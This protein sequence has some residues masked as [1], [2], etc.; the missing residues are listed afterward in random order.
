MVEPAPSRVESAP[1]TRLLRANPAFRALCASRAVSFLGDGIATTVLVLLAAR[2]DGPAGVS[3]LLI[4]NAL[5]RFG[6]PLAGVLAD[7]FRIRRLMMTCELASA[8]VFGLIAAVLPPLPVLIGLVAAVS[9]LATIRNPAGRSLVPVLV[10]KGD[11]TA[12][13]ALFGL[14]RTLQLAAGPG[15]GGLLVAGPGGLHTALAV[16]AATFV[17]SALLLAELPGLAPVRDPAEATGVWAEAAAGLRY[18]AR[19][20]QVRVLVVTLFL[21]VAFAA[22]DNVALVFL[23]R[24]QLSASPGGYG[25][26]ASAF[27]VGMLVAALACTR[28]A[29]RRS[30][31]TLIV[32]AVAAS[33]AGAMLTG[34]APTLVAVVAA[35]L[36]AGAGNAGENI[37]YDTAIQQV[38]PR[39][40]LAR[41][42]GTL[43]TAAQLGAAFAYIA[44]GLLVEWVGAR[45]TFVMAGSATLA[46]LIILIPAIRHRSDD[47][48]NCP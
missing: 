35:Q 47:L 41:V 45:A 6:G 12:A 36:I 14:G 4:A 1:R 28:L 11:R 5:P 24:N 48:D 31:A 23:I 18:V 7:R 8:A 3:L 34:L 38:V 32:V 19:H 30:P 21:V 37:G 42:F 22:V 25:L 17:V 40:F 29:R 20:R 9:T 39:Q 33:G 26:A 27:G 2:R 10:G 15:L 13:N 44:G 43:G 16:D 46:V